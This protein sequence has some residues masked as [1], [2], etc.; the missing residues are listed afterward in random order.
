MSGSDQQRLCGAGM[1]D[2]GAHG[3]PAS[4]LLSATT[5]LLHAAL[6][7]ARS[8]PGMESEFAAAFRHAMSAIPNNLSDKMLLCACHGALS[9]LAA[10]YNSFAAYTL[11]VINWWN[12]PDVMFTLLR[13]FMQVWFHT[14]VNQVKHYSKSNQLGF[15]AIM[16]LPCSRGLSCC[17]A[18]LQVRTCSCRHV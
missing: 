14:S 16:A 8:V 2:L 13:Q 10:G 15:G 12:P 5:R 9:C 11:A 6:P 7:S 18:A 3:Q 1:A 4:P 17:F